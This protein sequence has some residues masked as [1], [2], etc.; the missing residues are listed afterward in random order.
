MDVPEGQ[1][2]AILTGAIHTCARVW[3][4]GRLVSERRLGSS[5]VELQSG[6]IRPHQRE[7]DAPGTQRQVVGKKKDRGGGRGQGR[8][9]SKVETRRSNDNDDD[10]K[11]TAGQIARETPD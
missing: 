11:Q 4:R 5:A 7:G 3:A 8:M 1:L 10:S 9:R 2:R 6:T